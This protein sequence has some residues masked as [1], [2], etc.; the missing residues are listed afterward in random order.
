MAGTLGSE[1]LPRAGLQFDFHSLRFG[2]AIA[3]VTLKVRYL[4]D[5]KFRPCY[6]RIPHLLSSSHF[7]S[8]S[9]LIRDIT[10]ICQDS[11]TAITNRKTWACIGRV[12]Q[13]LLTSIGYAGV[14]GGAR[15]QFTLET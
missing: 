11:T 9:E 7:S 13:E 6:P 2:T 15:D 3:F 1:E 10:T 4:Y 8:S 14:A 5:T 12:C